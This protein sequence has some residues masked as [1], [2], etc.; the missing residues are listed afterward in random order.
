MVGIDSRELQAWDV[1]GGQPVFPKPLRARVPCEVGG[2][3]SL[4]VVN[5]DGSIG[6]WDLLT[7]QAKRSLPTTVAPY[8][9]ALNPDG[10][11]LA[12]AYGSRGASVEI[13]GTDSGEKVIELPAGSAGYVH[14][15]A[16]HPNGRQLALGFEGSEGK[17]QILEA[18][19]RRILATLEGQAQWVGELAFHPGGELL[20]SLS[21]D[22]TS[23]LWDAKTS[24]LLVNW[25]AAIGDLHFNRAGTVC[26]FAVIGGRARLMEVAEGREYRTFVKSSGAGR[27]EY[28]E[29]D[30]SA[31]GLLAV[32]MDDGIRLWEI[33]TGREVAFLP[34]RR[35]DSVSFVARPDGRELLTA[36]FGGL[37]R[38]PIH[39]DADGPERV[40]IGPP[41][42]VALPIAPTRADVEQN[43]RAVAVAGESS[44]TA[45]VVDLLTGAVRCTL[46]P[47]PGL[48]R[49]VISPDGRWVATSGWHS[50][51]V[52]V[53]DAR[54]GSLVKELPLGLNI[55]AFFSPDGR[56]LVTSRGDEYRS[57]DVPS[58]LPSLRLPWEI[59]SYPGWVAFSPDR[60][61]LAMERSPA[62]IHL[63]DAATGRTVAK[64]ED[65]RADIAQWLGFTEDGTRLVAISSFSRAIH[66][67]DLR[68]IREYLAGMKLDW[69]SHSHPGAPEA[70]ARRARRE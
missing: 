20:V 59:Q 69:E 12:V 51:V 70:D 45:L 44:G 3:N 46:V 63:V 64:L 38:W 7:G 42:V 2:D 36:G 24:R 37:R 49:A 23:R 29:G 31:D 34:D 41:R 66:V 18:A 61:L 6:V 40:R 14:A 9:I 30:I 50:E 53:W 21:G 26:G 32:G 33:T 60:S 8:K 56:T 55:V 58:W 16:W 35:T 4:L 67:W 13:W 17:I 22:G 54:T 48:N 43:G 47:H 11:Q 25:P 19:D 65:A 15:L 52:K 5:L 39:A 10:R 27:G 57:W 68:A 62:V 1:E 28:R